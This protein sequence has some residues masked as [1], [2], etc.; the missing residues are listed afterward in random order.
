MR[1]LVA[2]ATGAIGNP[3]IPAL[4]AAGHEVAGIATSQFGL[5]ALNRTGA[6][7]FIANALDSEAVDAVVKLV[8]PAAVIDELTS[9][10]KHYTAPEMRAAAERDRRIRLEGG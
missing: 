1:V 9:L 7:G 6:E 2:G 4:L 3:L 10:P 8:K 5:A